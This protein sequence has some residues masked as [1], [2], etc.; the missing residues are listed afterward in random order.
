MNT[1]PT[2]EQ[3][4]R[5]TAEYCTSQYTVMEQWFSHEDELAKEFLKD[6][7]FVC[8]IDYAIRKVQEQIRWNKQMAGYAAQHGGGARGVAKVVGNVLGAW[9]GGHTTIDHELSTW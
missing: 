5:A 3:V 1:T 2:H 6:N 9:V 4:A 8:S 7:A